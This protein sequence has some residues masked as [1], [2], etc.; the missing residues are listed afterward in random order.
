MRK[1]ES[2]KDFFR[3]FND[4]SSLNMFIILRGRFKECDLEKYGIF[5]T[6]KPADLYKRGMAQP[7]RLRPSAFGGT[8]VISDKIYWSGFI[9]SDLKEK[10]IQEEKE[11]IALERENE[12]ADWNDPDKED[13]E[14]IR[15][16]A[17]D[18]LETIKF[19]NSHQKYKL[20]RIV[21]L[22]DRIEKRRIEN[23]DAES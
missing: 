10:L 4:I 13:L 19:K 18:L 2:V 8:D 9:I 22:V 7:D 12:L 6:Y 14:T 16:E 17:L 11:K 1:G 15:K 20:K 3:R 5:K 21:E 23:T